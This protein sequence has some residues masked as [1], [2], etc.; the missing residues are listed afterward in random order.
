M[1]DRRSVFASNTLKDLT[2]AQL[3]TKAT[4]AIELMVKNGLD[5][6]KNIAILS[7]RKLPHG[8]ILYEFES[9]TSTAWISSPANRRAFLDHFGPEVIVKDRLYHLIVENVPISFDPLSAATLS[10]IERKSGLAN[11]SITRAKYIKPIARRNSNQRTAHITL[12]LKSKT[13]ANQAINFG[14]SIEGK[15]VYARKLLPEPTRC[16]K[17]HSF[18]AGHMANECTQENEK[19]GTCALDHR[20]SQCTMTF[21]DLFHCVNC[22]VDGHAA[23]SRDCPTFIKKWQAHKSRN[24]DANYRFFPTDDPNTWE[25]VNNHHMEDLKAQPYHQDPQEIQRHPPPQNEPQEWQ[26]VHHRK[27]TQKVSTKHKENA[28]RIPL[29]TQSRLTDAWSANRPRQPQGA[30]RP[31]PSTPAQSPKIT[32]SSSPP[33]WTPSST[34]DINLVGTNTTTGWD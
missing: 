15:K 10:E 23:W 14:L 6:P 18:D 17:C 27:P 12:T 29:G 34:E 26:T 22:G 4:L 21:P 25:T 8:G 32:P 31:L 13:S 1:I 2:E 24:D 5:A 16:L 19:C 9:N 33:Y 3:V 30:R 7:A 28:N 20:T 11:N